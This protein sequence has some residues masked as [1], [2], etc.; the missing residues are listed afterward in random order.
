MEL[1]GAFHPR[2]A[3][4]LNLTPDHLERHGD[5]D[6]YAGHKVRMFARM[7]P[8]DACVIPADD[9]RLNRLAARS[10]GRRLWI[11]AEPGVAIQ[12]D[13]AVFS[14]VRADDRG[15]FALPFAAFPLPGAHN[16][17]NVATAVLLCLAV[18][19]DPEGISL[20]GLQG[21]P[22]RMELVAERAGVRWI[23]DSKATNVEAA[24]AAYQGFDGPFVAL[25]GGQSKR[26][27]AWPLLGRPLRVA[28]SV[29]CFGAAGHEIANALALEG[30]DAVEVAGLADAVAA[31]GD[32]ARPGDAVLLSPAC[33]S[34][35]AYTNYEER[36]A[37]F[38]TLVGS[39]T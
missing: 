17:W 38:R 12:P 3:A 9:A 39:L 37:H 16:R 4:I 27:S 23:D 2:A 36:G 34:F 24:L 18:G 30:V 13:R 26:G 32:A 33:A 6:T 19:V 10:P 31:A 29:I 1:P 35:D 15:R 11:G 7:G 8:D 20:A 21:L 14:G 5:M 25:L 22:H 28:R